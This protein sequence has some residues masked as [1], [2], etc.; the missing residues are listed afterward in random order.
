MRRLALVGSM[1]LLAACGGTA[2]NTQQ[3][4][5]ACEEAFTA[6]AGVDAMADSV[7]DLYPAVRACATIE[8]WTAAF[9]EN[10]GAGFLGSATDVLRNVCMAPEIA[11]EPLCAMVQ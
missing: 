11:D 9:D 1:V 5:D 8:A 6:A 4:A 7:S 10:D 2:G 3:A